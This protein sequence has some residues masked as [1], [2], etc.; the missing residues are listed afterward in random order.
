MA[1]LTRLSKFLA[2][3][4][5]HDAEKFHVALDSEGFTDVDAVWTIIQKRYPGQYD[6]RD[7]LTVVEGDQTGKKR[8]EIREGRIRAM[9]GHS[10]VNPISYPVA[11]PPEYLY[12]GTT[13]QALP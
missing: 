6:Y 12:H 7:L 8:Y 3:V 5:R 2:V 4:L 13:P 10:K 11:V 9:F 1:N